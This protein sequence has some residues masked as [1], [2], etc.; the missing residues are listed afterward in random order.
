VKQATHTVLLALVA[1]AVA[2]CGSAQKPFGTAPV[3]LRSGDL[4]GWRAVPDPP[5]IGA[6]APDLSGL[7]VTGR[8]DSPALVH[9]GDAVRA[10]TL[11]F[12]TPAD[13]AEALA[14]SI[15][16]G[17]APALEAALR[18]NV[19]ARSAGPH[20][21]GYRLSVPRPAEP[22]HDTVELY[23]VRRGRTLA[24][25]EFVSGTGFDPALRGRILAQVSR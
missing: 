19:E 1:L 16:P 20:R 2:G 12:A 18:G 5:G 3:L 9:A 25:V 17:Y 8:A 22:G 13:A 15:G 14:R 10:T 21:I 6:L 23:V 7:T 24:L 4:P 11:V